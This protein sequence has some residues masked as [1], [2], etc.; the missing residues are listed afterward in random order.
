MFGFLKDKIKSWLGKSKKEVEEKA[1]KKEI[2]V[3]P[4]KETKKK[5]E[6]IKEKPAKKE[7]RRRTTAEL[8]EERA[9]TKELLEDVQKEGLEIKSPEEKAE[10]MISGLEKDRELTD[11]G[12]E[13][14][15]EAEE[16]EEKEQ[17]IEEPKK[18]GFFERLKKVFTYTLTEDR[19]EEIFSELEMLLLESNVALEVVEKIKSDLK[20]ELVGK[21]IKKD[22][23]ETEIQN[24]LKK[25]IENILI[26]PEDMMKKIKDF[27]KNSSEPF[28]VL[29]FGINGAGKTTSI[30]KFAKLLEKNKLSCVMAAADTFRAAAIEQLAIHADKLQVKIIKGNYGADPA[31]VGF[32][33]IK[34]AKS[35]KIDVV[36]IDT[37]GR[38]H[39]K[40]NLLHEMEKISRVTKPN[41]KVFVAEAVAG[42]DA[43][44]QA[45]AFNELIGVD[46]SVLSKVDVDEKGGTILSVGYI[47]KKPILYLG[48]GQNYEDFELF[49][50]KKFIE[51]LGL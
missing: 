25:S 30:A 26:E 32:E 33:A 7:K 38:M 40:E 43:T 14:Q 9:V 41:L 27:R 20:S 22:K 45:K 2:A 37:A 19:F 4:V 21:E 34:Y 23:I 13:I 10:E 50:K 31:S 49:N 8:K 28:I 16:P 51:R 47:T 15:E 42:N 24:A 29:F 48:M 12:E 36:L 11:I 44:E 1:K 35:N 39:T 17:V 6:K 18:L 46:G 5:E 3:T